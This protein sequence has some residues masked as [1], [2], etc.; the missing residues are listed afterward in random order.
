[1]RKFYPFLSRL[2]A[3]ILL[4]A[5]FTSVKAQQLKISD[6][7]IFGMEQARI[8]IQSIVQGGATGSNKLVKTVGQAAFYGNIHS[9]GK[10]DLGINNTVNGIVTAANSQN[11]TGSIL[12]AGLSASFTGNIDVKGNVTI[13][14]GTVAGKVTI[15]TNRTYSG[16]T[17]TLGVVKGT[18]VFPVLPVTSSCCNFSRSWYG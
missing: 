5:S 3:I 18:P 6:F 17:P 2:S 13:T 9:G 4:L 16:P 15:P 10:I 1:M 7:S 12:N 8:S 14:S 11:L